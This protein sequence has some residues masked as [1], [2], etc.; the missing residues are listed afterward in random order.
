MIQLTH[1]GRRT[2][3]NA[4]DWLPVVSS[5]REP[6][7]RAYPKLIKDWDMDRIA[8]DNGDAVEPMQAAGL[9]GFELK[10]YGHLLDSF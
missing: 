5:G 6:A 9:D 1:L 2:Y 8:K 3:W 10:C 4:G 7:H